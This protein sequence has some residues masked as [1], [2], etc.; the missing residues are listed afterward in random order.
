M[1]TWLG[2][3]EHWLDNKPGSEWSLATL[4][5]KDGEPTFIEDSRRNVR[6]SGFADKVHMLGAPSAVGLRFLR[7]LKEKFDLI[8]ID[9]DHSYS[10]VASDLRRSKSLLAKHG[11]LAGDD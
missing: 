5:I 9:G 10:S 11:T 1:D 8:C 6:K 4:N 3:T 7:N 2:S